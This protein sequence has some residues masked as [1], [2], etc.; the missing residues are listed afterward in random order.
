MAEQLINNGNGVA[1]DGDPTTSTP[2]T[3]ET[4][5]GD[6]LN[7]QAAAATSPGHTLSSLPKSWRYTSL[8]PP[9]PTFPT[10]ADSHKT[11]RDQITPR[12]VRNGLFTWVRPEKQQDPELLAVS[13][14]ALRD[15]D[16]RPSEAMTDEFRQLAAGNLLLGWDDQRLEGGYPWA[17]LYG[18]FQFGQWAGQLGD[19]RAISLFETTSAAVR[20]SWTGRDETKYEVQ[21]KGAGMTPYSRFADGKAVLRSSVR[22]FV[23]SEALNA[24]GIPSTRALALSLLPH[25]KVRRETVEP[26]AIVVRFAQSWVRLGNFDILRARGDR[27]MIRKLATYVAEEVLGGWDRLPGRLSDPENPTEAP[28]LRHPPRGV[29]GEKDVQGPSEAAENRFARLYREVVRRN[30]LTV[31]KWQTYGFM[32]GVL[33]T[34]NTSIQGL[35]IDFGPFAFMDNFDP[36]YTPN[37]DDHML[38]YSYRNQP[39][40]IWWNLVRFGEAVGELIGAGESVDTEKFIVDGVSEG[41]EADELI[42][43]AEKLITQAG[44]EYKALFLTE[45]KKLM[46]AR[47]GL[48]VFQESDYQDLFSSLLDTME[49]LE[50]DFN[51]FYRRLSFIKVEDLKTEEARKEKAGVFFHKEGISASGVTEE[52]ARQRVAG[53]LE[54]WRVRVVEDWGTA[55]AD[56]ERTV[57]PAKEEERMAAMKKV[58]PSFIPRSFILDEVIQRVEKGGERDVLRR[59]M[60]M[61]LHPFEEQWDDSS[62]LSL[63]LIG[64]LIGVISLLI[65]DPLELLSNVIAHMLL[66]LCL[67]AQPFRVLIMGD[68]TTVMIVVIPVGLAGIKVAPGSYRSRCR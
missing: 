19:G 63:E 7:K 59:V 30:A 42:S 36:A 53:W 43:R 45:Y 66:G 64:S 9:D 4:L 44:E 26:G 52:E 56:G 37:H 65:L 62:G 51:H 39:T 27:P 40:I 6:S 11:P 57:E 1:P 49:A 15:L 38:R 29:A 68:T 58:N 34:D 54:G 35:S 41:E 48:R 18:G 3:K 8:L 16:I 60:H 14:A 31:A 33:N 55:A 20:D 24:L 21:L 50:L 23:V 22:E 67:L 12:Q 13:P 25:T 32:N 5:D 46:T 47:L 28:E 10:P 61:A 2:L 17:Q